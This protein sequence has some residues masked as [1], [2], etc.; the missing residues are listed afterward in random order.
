MRADVQDPEDATRAVEE[1]VKA[2]GGLDILVNNAGVGS[3]RATSP[4]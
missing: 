2:F 3:F 1:G 4:I